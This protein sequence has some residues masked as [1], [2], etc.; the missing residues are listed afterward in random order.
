[1]AFFR[2]VGVEGF[3]ALVSEALYPFCLLAAMASLARRLVARTPTRAIP[4]ARGE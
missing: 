4:A 1:M 3:S 2:G